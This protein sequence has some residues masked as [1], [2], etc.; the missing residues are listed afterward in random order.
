MI[1]Q[2]LQKEFIEERNIHIP[3]EDLLGPNQ[4]NVGQRHA[5]NIILHYINK[6]NS[7][8]FFVDGLG[9]TGKTYLYRALFAT[10]RS[11]SLIALAVAT[12]G[13]ATSILPGGRTAHSRFKIPLE[14]DDILHVM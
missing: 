12:S 1:H 14:S 2:K 3:P 13:I 11:Q 5:Y 10:I 4:L 7:G 8:A 6:Q 9:G